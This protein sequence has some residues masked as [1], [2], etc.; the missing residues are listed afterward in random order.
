MGTIV[1]RP[2][3]STVRSLLLGLGA[4]TDMASRVVLCSWT[5]DRRYIWICSC[6]PA[7]PGG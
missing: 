1:A 5:A 3:T 6:D 4:R 2:G 7:R